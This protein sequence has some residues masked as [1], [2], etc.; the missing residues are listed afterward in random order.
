MLS[1]IQ[2]LKLTDS[3]EQHEATAV[4]KNCPL[5]RNLEQT[6]TLEGSHLVGVVGVKRNMTMK[7]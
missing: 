2:Q 7:I 5:G 4:G 6:P 1:T 3:P